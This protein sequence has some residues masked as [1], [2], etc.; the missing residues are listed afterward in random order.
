[1]FQVIKYLTK[2]EN[3]MKCDYEIEGMCC[4]DKSPYCADF[5]PTTEYPYTCK[6]FK[7]DYND[8]T[9]SDIAEES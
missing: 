4:N 3:N 7:I 8:L 5:C 2:G 9:N 1:M 6:F